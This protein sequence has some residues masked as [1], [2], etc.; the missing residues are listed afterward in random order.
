MINVIPYFFAQLIPT[1]TLNSV[2]LYYDIPL[3]NNCVISLAF[4]IPWF[5]QCWY[6]RLLASI[7]ATGLWSCMHSSMILH[8][9]LLGFHIF[10]VVCDLTAL[11]LLHLDEERSGYH[12]V[13]ESWPRFRAE[14]D[15][16]KVTVKCAASLNHYRYVVYHTV[17]LRGPVPHNLILWYLSWFL[18]TSLASA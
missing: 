17:C 2:L 15:W 1:P 14:L 18:F 16:W 13:G 12:G 6:W 5:N 9:A 4:R 7:F 10:I 3:M 11:F 8:K